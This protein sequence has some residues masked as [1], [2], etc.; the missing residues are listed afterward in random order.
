ML[1]NYIFCENA[2]FGSISWKIDILPVTAQ[3]KFESENSL[4]HMLLI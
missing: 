3:L 4:A 2:K 1:K